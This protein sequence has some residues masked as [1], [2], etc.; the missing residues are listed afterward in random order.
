MDKVIATATEAIADVQ[1]GATIMFGAF[2]GPQDWAG[3]LIL[4]LR[5]KGVRDLTAISNGGGREEFSVQGLAKDGR[6]R[7]FIATFGVSPYGSTPISEQIAAGTLEYELVP[8]GTFVE[9]I[10]AAA[11]GIPA[12][13]TPTGAGTRT[14]EG[15]E[16]RV[17]NGRE[18][19]LERALAADFAFV[20]AWKADRMGNL[21]Y[22]GSTRNFNTM[23]AAAARVTIAEVDEIVETGELDP[24]SIHT[25]AI[26]VDRV[27]QTAIS[28]AEVR[29]RFAE[30]VHIR[31]RAD[32]VRVEPGAKPR[33]T[34]ELIA[35][36]AANLLRDGQWVNL[37]F[38]L[39]TRVADFVFDREV[40]LHAENGLANYG[41]I[42]PL[43]GDYDLHLY[44]AS[45]QP[46][47]IRPGAAI[48]D[49]VDAFLMA[50]G[51]HVDVVVLG[52]YQVSAAGDF[53]SWIRPGQAGG[54]MGGA[55]DLCAGAKEV[56]ILMQHTTREGA[57]RLLRECSYPLTARGVVTWL[58][59]D[60]GLF[61]PTP[62]GMVIEETA[63]GW[64]LDEIQAL[65]E[66]RLIP[67]ATLGELRL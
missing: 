37:G 19:V 6:L 12:F 59:T 47:T 66:A 38:G 16:V 48:F 23:M 65:T 35:M 22:R 34:P 61:R 43:D 64:S 15:K 50:R 45:S 33:L 63:P 8:Q 13:Y 39:P 27:V 32:V 51:G 54:G 14:A 56:I 67:S 40:Y 49:S 36:R 17:F 25:P 26:F 57:P 58:V 7:K 10:R 9:R 3:S 46:V 44:N 4:A 53:A 62:D 18:H 29:Q 24:E 20:R 1:D 11:G 60:L 42:A 55:M 41:P 21:I 31:T 28:T 2:G 52:A 5:E 30:L